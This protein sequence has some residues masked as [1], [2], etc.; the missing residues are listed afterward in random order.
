MTVDDL[1]IEARG[2]LPHRP[3]PAQALAAQAAGTVALITR[4]P[5]SGGDR[6]SCSMPA[7]ATSS[8]HLDTG[9]LQG[10]MQV[11]PG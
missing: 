10:R 5:L 1:L 4:P 2:V 3:G 7:P 8:R 6:F 11:A 9:H